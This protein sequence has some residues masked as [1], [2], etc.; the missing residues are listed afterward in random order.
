MRVGAGPAAV[1]GGFGGPGAMWTTVF[2]GALLLEAELVGVL[3]V[4]EFDADPAVEFGE[5]AS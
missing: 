4:V 3:A 5:S 1:A 2:L